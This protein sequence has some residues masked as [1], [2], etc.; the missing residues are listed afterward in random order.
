MK[1]FAMSW[2]Q[3]ININRHSCNSICFKFSSKEMRATDCTARCYPQESQI[4]LEVLGIFWKSLYRTLVWV[5][6]SAQGSDAG[7]SWYHVC[8]LALWP[9]SHPS[10]F[11]SM[12]LSCGNWVV[13][14]LPAALTG[15]G[16]SRFP[17][18]LH[19]SSS[20]LWA[21]HSP[22]TLLTHMTLGPFSE[23]AQ[24][25]QGKVPWGAPYNTGVTWSFQHLSYS[26]MLNP[27]S[28]PDN[29]P[30]S[31]E[32]AGSRFGIRPDLQT[33]YSQEMCSQVHTCVFGSIWTKVPLKCIPTSDSRQ[34]IKVLWLTP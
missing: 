1:Y 23:W 19:V 10:K 5:K 8:W 13:S 7:S 15:A 14:L 31:E 12:S 2:S 6:S 18:Q 25:V 4:Y 29:I 27:E 11:L 17:D 32:E 3:D 9:D 34:L 22:Q 16:L 26:S 20:T 21:A 24:L 33:W 30:V 28:S